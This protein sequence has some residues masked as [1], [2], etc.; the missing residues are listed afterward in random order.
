M[1][2]NI[3][4]SFTSE[5][6]ATLSEPSIVDRLKNKITIMLSLVEFYKENPN[7]L[8]AQYDKIKSESNSKAKMTQKEQNESTPLRTSNTIHNDEPISNLL[9][10]LLPSIHIIILLFLI[11]FIF[12]ISYF[13]FLKTTLNTYSSIITTFSTNSEIDANVYAVLTVFQVMIFTNQT[14]IEMQEFYG[15]EKPTE[16]YIAERIKKA[17]SNLYYV[18]KEESFR[19]NKITP[20]RDI[21]NLSCDTLL[22][23]VDDQILHDMISL[24][25]DK[26]K[27][28]NLYN[29]LA[30][31][32]KYYDF[33]EYKND[34]IFI[35]EI[36][37]RAMELNNALVH[38]IDNLY[39]INIS[40]KLFDIYLFILLF[41]RPLRHFESSSIYLNVINNTNDTYNIVIYT[42]LVI[43]TIFEILLLI[44]LRKFVVNEYLYTNKS[45]NMLT[46]CL[47]V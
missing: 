47:K 40:R 24:F 17:Y 22:N 35:R 2:K 38:S 41:Y 36:L 30:K 31:I 25:A 44:L 37:F 34:K 20:L 7:K 21:I 26:Y 43:H 6:K 11:Y 3:L 23:N 1:F 46:K 32:C 42:F 16:G 14:D 13:L 8:S 5:I 45:L 10:I 9:S 18:E 33:M 19:Q 4:F 29:E 39:Q 27:D 28:I 12:S 15:N